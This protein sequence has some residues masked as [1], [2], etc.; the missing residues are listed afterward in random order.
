MNLL[1]GTVKEDSNG[2]VY[3]DLDNELIYKTLEITRQ[4]GYTEPR[5]EKGAHVKI[6]EGFE[7]KE[8]KRTMLGEVVRVEP[9]AIKEAFPNLKVELT[10]NILFK[11]RQE[12]TG[13]V[14]PPNGKC[15]F[16]VLATKDVKPLRGHGIRERLIGSWMNNVMKKCFSDED[17]DWIKK[18]DEWS[19]AF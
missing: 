15:F 11:I 13:K 9:V 1:Q 12:L 6:A 18:T 10:S 5:L 3:L 14:S 17:K 8:N 16:I 19:D 4:Y 2:S 7:V